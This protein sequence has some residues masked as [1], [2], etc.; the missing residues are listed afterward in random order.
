MELRKAAQTIIDRAIAAAQPG[1]AVRRA[2]E[3]QP[4]SG[5]LYV[6]AIGKAAW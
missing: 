5:A 6:V 3:Q 2:L 4:L 1:E